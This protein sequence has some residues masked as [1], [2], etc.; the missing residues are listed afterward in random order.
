MNNY[1]RENDGIKGGRVVFGAQ[2]KLKMYL[3][4]VIWECS[5]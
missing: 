3:E 2:T 1:E 5:W 4:G